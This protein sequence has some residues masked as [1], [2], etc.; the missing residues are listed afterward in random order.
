MHHSFIFKPL[1]GVE[2]NCHTILI[3][4]V[5]W[6]SFI[7]LGAT[8]STWLTSCCFVYGEMWQNSYF[9]LNLNLD[10]LHVV[11]IESFCSF[12]FFKEYKCQDFCYLLDYLL[13]PFECERIMRAN[14]LH[15]NVPLKLAQWTGDQSQ[16]IKES[17]EGKEEKAE[18]CFLHHRR[19]Q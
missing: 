1:V 6:S 9:P 3:S 13:S 4:F 19:R 7:I 8:V 18:R 10:C 14:S 2:R 12:F 17:M 11:C 5:L 16:W 15:K